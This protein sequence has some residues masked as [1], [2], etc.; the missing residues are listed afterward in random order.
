[1]VHVMVEMMAHKSMSSLE[2]NVTIWSG[3]IARGMIT[4]IRGVTAEAG[5]GPQPVNHIISV[6]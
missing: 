1:M 4:G 3:S 5:D 6:Y 2:S